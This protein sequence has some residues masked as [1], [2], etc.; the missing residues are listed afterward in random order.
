MWGASLQSGSG[1]GRRATQAGGYLCGPFAAFGAAG[2]YTPPH[3][4]YTMALIGAIRERSWLLIVLI[5]LAM[6]GFIFMDMFSGKGNVLGGGTTL[7]EVEGEEIDQRQFEQAYDALYTNSQGDVFQQRAGLWNYMVEDKLVRREA[8]AV[9]LGVPEEELNDLTYGTTLSPIIQQRFRDP[10]TGQVNR[11]NLNS[12]RDA[13]ADGTLGDPT[14]VDPSRARFWY[15]QKREINKQRLQDKLAGLVAKSMYTPDWMAE[16]LAKGQ[17]TRVD[18]AYVKVPYENI[19]DEQVQLADAD[20][21]AWVAAEGARF[22]RTQPGR[23]VRYVSF[24]VAPT[25]GDSAAIRARLAET[26]GNWADAPDDSVFVAQ[27]RGAFPAAY[28]AQ[29]FLPEAVAAAAVGEVVGPYED[30]A[31]YTI[32]KVVDRKVIPDSVRSRHILLQAETRE[33]L[34]RAQNTADSIIDLVQSGQATF[35]TLA[36]QLSIGPTATKG[37]DLGYVAP[38]AMVGPFNDLIFYQAEE[39]EL[40]TVLTQFGL[41]VVE[42]TG[43]KFDD[44]A[45]PASRVAT[46]SEAIEPSKETQDARYEAASRFAQANR[47]LEALEAAAAADANLELSEGVVVGANDYIVG[48][49]G[50]S[51]S[52]R[53]IIKYAFKNDAGDVSPNVYAFKAPN[54]F[55]DGRYVV[56]AVAA[57]VPEG[58]PTAAVARAAYADQVRRMKKAAAVAQEGSI[59]AIAARYGVEADTARAVNFGSGF[60]P[61]LGAEPRAIAQAFSLPT[62]QMSGGIAGNSGVVV[63]VP[64][65]RTE[66]GDVS[67]QVAN[68]RRTNDAQ[69]ASG[70]RNRFGIA[71]RDAADVEDDRARFY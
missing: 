41:H 17:N 23:V 48:G 54:A 28:T 18:L 69:T 39:G 4:L 51:N 66:P 10:Q 45:A 11:D 65:V 12:F 24:D 43:R 33:Q 62:N 30:G 67:A 1:R 40:R 36:R 14:V 42:V 38:G 68:V 9:G 19:P 26:A 56:A 13:E 55:Y 15:F 25:A 47:T 20:Y 35:D 32:A 64:L 6:A 31:R 5:G 63:V 34:A 49:L 37:G 50:S 22:R 29:E 58:R 44:D 3:T 70:V 60:V 71:L 53:D 2:T 27:Q 61:G 16:E 57:E 52:S 21:E 8:R 7:G 46:I 59:T